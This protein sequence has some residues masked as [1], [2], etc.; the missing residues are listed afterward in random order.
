MEERRCSYWKSLVRRLKFF[1]VLLLFFQ[2]LSFADDFTDFFNG[3]MASE[4][5]FGMVL[6]GGNTQVTSFLLNDTFSYRTGLNT[7]LYR[8][9]YASTEVRGNDTSLRWS[10][11]IRYQ[12]ELSE[13]F[14]LF[15]G[16]GLESDLFQKILQRYSTDLGGR[17]YHYRSTVFAFVS[18]AGYRFTRTN[19]TE[20]VTKHHYFRLFTEAE[21]F[22]NKSVS[23]KLSVELLP[24]LSVSA[25]YKLNSELSLNALLTEVFSLKLAYLYRYDHQ[26]AAGVKYLSDSLFTTTAVA[27][28]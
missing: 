13:R 17:V 9:T 3:T 15:I 22:F 12:R 21:R 1:F 19:Y 2:T 6:T 28:F 14:S 24:N 27:R 7:F 25:A 5:E 26:P 8:D 23:G 10:F 4:T 16:Q 20:Y 11:G 18:E